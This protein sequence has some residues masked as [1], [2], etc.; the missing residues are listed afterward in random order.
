M[1]DTSFIELVIRSIVSLG[2]VLVLIGLAYLVAKRRAGVSRPSTRG[3]SR[4]R[5]WTG[6][7][8]RG[9][10][11]S[12][13]RSRQHVKR[14]PAV[15]ETLGRIGLSRGSVAMAVRFGDQVVLLGLAD[16]APITVLQ[17]MPAERWDELSAVERVVTTS[18]STDVLGNET[19]PD[20]RPGFVEALR[21]ATVRRA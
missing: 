16:G 8:A 5:G 21:E 6:A 14:E 20:R 7:V 9:S 11:T 15:L 3:G 12:S 10:G 1:G 17:E 2:I 4:A 13:G 18:V 19:A